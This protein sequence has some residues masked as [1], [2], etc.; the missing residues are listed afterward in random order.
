[1]E[2]KKIFIKILAIIGT[3]F[4]WLPILAPVLFSAARFFQ[5][6]RFLFDYL[7][8]AEL[9]PIALLGAVLLMVATGIAELSFFT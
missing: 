9:F 7:M 8:P 1:M 6:N 5:S 3:L 4:V 2:N